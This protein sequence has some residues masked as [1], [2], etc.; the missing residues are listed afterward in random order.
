[1]QR[2]VASNP[3]Y[4]DAYFRLGIALEKLNKRLE[5]SRRVEN[6]S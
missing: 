2:A 6:F 4:T 5:E 1:L 3:R